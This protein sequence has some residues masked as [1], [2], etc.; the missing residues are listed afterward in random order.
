MPSK[1]LFHLSSK[2]QK[3]SRNF[4]LESD[5]HANYLVIPFCVAY[6]LQDIDWNHFADIHDNLPELINRAGS[7]VGVSEAYLL[8]ALRGM[9]KSDWRVYQIHK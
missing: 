4:V 8:K 1:D 3:S 9:Q 5:L 2:L 7:M 6:Q